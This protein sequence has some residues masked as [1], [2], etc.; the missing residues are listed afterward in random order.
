[1]KRSASHETPQALGKDD[2]RKSRTL[3]SGFR[4]IF[5]TKTRSKSP[6]PFSSSPSLNAQIETEYPKR[7]TPRLYKSLSTFF[8]KC[9]R[10]C[11]SCC[12]CCCGISATTDS[13]PLYDDQRDPS[14]RRRCYCRGTQRKGGRSSIS[15]PPKSSPPPPT[16]LP[17]IRHRFVEQF[18]KTGEPDYG[19][20]RRERRLRYKKGVKEEVLFSS[21]GLTLTAEN[22]REGQNIK[23]EEEDSSDS[24]ATVTIEPVSYSLKI[25]ML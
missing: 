15:E 9:C 21:A 11:C 14:R 16:A 13:P 24:S 23:Q 3:S 12:G 7:P 6:H 5:R 4:N 17:L 25:N 2:H 8:N 22:T 19:L 10:G 20:R 1:M 18:T